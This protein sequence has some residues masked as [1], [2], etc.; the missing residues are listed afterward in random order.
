MVFCIECGAGKENDKTKCDA[1][2]F[3]EPHSDQSTPPSSSLSNE[4]NVSTT[5]LEKSSPSPPPPPTSLVTPQ[6]PALPFEDSDEDLQDLPPPPAPVR[7]G[8]QIKFSTMTTDF[9]AIHSQVTAGVKQVLAIKEL[10]Q[11]VVKTEQEHV[12][13]MEK[14][15]SE[16][17]KTL[18]KIM[19]NDPIV[20]HSPYWSGVIAAFQ[21]KVTAS[22]QAT[23]RILIEVIDPLNTLE[24]TATLSLK[25]ISNTMKD[26]EQT[27]KKS[28]EA[29][30]KSKDVCRKTLE[31]MHDCFEKEKVEVNPKKKAELNAK[32]ASARTLASEQAKLVV[33]RVAEANSATEVFHVGLRS[34]LDQLEELEMQRLSHVTSRL[35]KWI[36][37]LKETDS[38]HVT[39]SK[40]A[41]DLI[42]GIDADRC[43]QTFIYDWI[44][45]YGEPAIQELTIYDLPL[46]SEEIKGGNVLTKGFQM[47]H[48]P[49]IQLLE[50]EKN[51][52]VVGLQV[53]PSTMNALIA[54]QEKTGKP[55]DIPLIM[56]VLCEAIRE[57]GGLE[58]QGIFRISIEANLLLELQKQ[59]DTGNFSL[60]LM[61]G[62]PH[63]AACLLKLWLRSLT[64]PVIHR[65]YYKKATE[66]LQTMK[67]NQVQIRRETGKVN[68]DS[69]AAGKYVLDIFHKLAPPYQALIRRIGNLCKEVVSHSDQNLMSYDALAVVFAPCFF[70]SPR[71]D[72]PMEGMQQSQR[73]KMFVTELLTT[74]ANGT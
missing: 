27:L 2:G 68:Q 13:K 61:K 4:D 67:N 33:T 51:S 28:V 26:L 24:K 66:G 15:L 29:M 55:I 6:P 25:N 8:E 21:A 70:R 71:I 62:D 39:H 22:K 40:T 38:L 64:D 43:L 60:D 10:F 50:K 58:T 48:L 53:S 14:A 57:M 23:D 9:I 49:L 19:D 35:H 63:A 42:K 41:F 59:F 1:C 31:L 73:E 45:D 56:H 34:C 18:A 12:K 65:D 69:S 30:N 47:F 3:E 46:T 7:V 52:S 44:A 11:H 54:Y 74:L 36:A 20:M 72:D 37:N 16:E 17:Q 5:L 32:Q